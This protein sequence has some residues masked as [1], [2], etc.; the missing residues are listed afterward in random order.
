MWE[1][2]IWDVTLISKSTLNF[3]YMYIYV[4]IYALF[5]LLDT[6]SYHILVLTN[7]TK[8]WEHG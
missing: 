6:V 4:M 8:D 7:F 2:E 3:L 5:I 1:G